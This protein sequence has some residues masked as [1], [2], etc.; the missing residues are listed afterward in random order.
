MEVD[1]HSLETYSEL[2]RT[3]AESASAA[4]S[5]LIG[6][7]TRV[8]ITGVSLLSPSDL[9]YEF[10]D[11]EFAGVSV[12]LG[13]PLSGE[14]VLAFD[15][16]G[17]TAITETLVPVDDPDRTQGAIVEV[18]N[19]M[20]NGFISGWADHLDTTVKPSPP[21][22]VEGSGLEVLPETATGDQSVFV[23]KSRVEAV[24]GGFEFRILLV[25]EIDSL[26]CL[27]E[28]RTDGGISVEKLEVFTEMTEQGA[29]KAADNIQTMTGL[30]ADVQVN[31]LN[32]TSLADIPG[33]VGDNQRVGTVVKYDGTPSG[34]LA[35]LF[36]PE[37]AKASVDAL[38]PMDLESDEE[39]SK[40]EQGALEELCN[41]MVSGFIDGWANVLQTSIK[42]S[43]P[44]FTADMGSSIVSPIIADVA[45]TV[46]YAFL[47]DSNIETADT[48]EVSCQLFALPHPKELEEALDDLLV[49]RADE[50]GADPNDLF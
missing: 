36:E 23:F 10:A 3:G 4:L 6:M 32:F 1:I 26:E 24:D 8:D 28:E 41:V 35:I 31:R 2:A 49:E 9:E 25:P 20:A 27:L 50:M 42:H 14:T 5:D 18:G 33:Q 44:T 19:I 38:M 21:E 12:G 16:G 17:Q 37:S 30:D 46:N 7:E 29:A 45:R 34:Y 15:E 13:E 11:R 22:Y 39:W 48:G 43:P 47:L 40:T